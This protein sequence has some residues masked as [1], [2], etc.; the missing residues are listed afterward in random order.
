[1]NET[2]VMALRRSELFRSLGDEDLRTLAEAF[3]EETFAAGEIV[4]AAGE[5]ADRI[6][7]VLEGT[8]EIRPPGHAGKPPIRVGPSALFG[9]YGMF[10]TGL[11][12]ATV[13]SLGQSRLLA[14]DYHRFRAFLLRF[15]EAMLAILGTTVRQLLKARR[16]S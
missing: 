11:R 2:R 4:L 5:P 1:M 16:Q 13:T 10:D 14:L 12:T 15:P 8:L 7:V 6:F 9:E 3:E